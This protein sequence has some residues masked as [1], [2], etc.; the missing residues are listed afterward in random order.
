METE[1]IDE[2]LGFEVFFGTQWRPLLTNNVIVTAGAAML[3]PGDGLEKIYQ[4][5]DVLWHVFVDL[6]LTW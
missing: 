1:A 5:D 6:T 2:A 4:S 3:V